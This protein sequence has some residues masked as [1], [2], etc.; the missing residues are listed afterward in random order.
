VRWK[1]LAAGAVTF[2]VTHAIVVARWTEW[3]AP[4][5]DH[6]P[7]FLNSGRAA[8]FTFGVVFAVALLAGMALRPPVSDAVLLGAN[9]AGGATV[10][11]VAT[12]IT[13]GPGTIFPI[14]IAIGWLMLNVSAVSG[15][16]I[17]RL[18]RPARP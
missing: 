1:A 13:I 4:A 5:A 10:A 9:V 8:A 11:M 17:A 16:L 7:W 14:V 15:T 18:L 6:V 12:L 3:F 2:L